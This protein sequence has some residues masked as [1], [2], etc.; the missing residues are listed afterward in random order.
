MN[1]ININYTE[2]Q[3]NWEELIELI[4]HGKEIM[5]TKADEPVAK[6]SPVV[7]ENNSSTIKKPRAEKPKREVVNDS[8]VNSNSYSEIWY[9]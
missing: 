2:S 4:L 5:L 1:R 6:I 7:P 3:N 8:S 9:G